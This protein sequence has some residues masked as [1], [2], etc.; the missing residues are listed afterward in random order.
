[1]T[2]SGRRREEQR[3]F[4]DRGLE[5]QRQENLAR[6]EEETLARRREQERAEDALR[7]SKT[8]PDHDVT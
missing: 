5:I 2:K 7:R 3:E 1:M 4:E 6:I 8:Y